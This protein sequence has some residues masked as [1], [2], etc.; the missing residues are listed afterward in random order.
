[1]ATTVLIVDDD[2]AIR[3]LLATFLQQEGYEPVLA[4]GGSDAL[5]LLEQLRPPPAIMLLDLVMPDLDG[6][7]VLDHLRRTG[8]DALPI[9][10]FSGHRPDPALLA[11]LDVAHRDFIAKPF[12]FD[13]LHLRLRRLLRQAAQESAAVDAGIRVYTL[14]ALRVYRG[15]TLLLDEG[16]PNTPAKSLLKVLLTASG[17]SVSTDTLMAHLWPEA[18]PAVAINRLRVAV[19]ELR[20]RLGDTGPSAAA[21]VIVQQA[22]AYA[23][24]PAGRCWT[25]VAAFEAALAQARTFVAQQSLEEALAAYQRAAA[26]YGGDFL[27]D[28]AGAEWSV[29][30]RE[31]LYEAYLTLLGELA[32]L[33]ARRGAV[34]AVVQQYRRILSLEPWR[35]E[36]YRRLMRY[37]ARAGRRSEALRVFAECR[38]ALAAEELEP[39]PTTW[40]LRNRIAAGGEERGQ[41]PASG[42]SEGAP[43]GPRLMAG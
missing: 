31:R 21:S 22:R 32:H 4:A 29:P 37:L 34:D 7:A 33:Q 42:P 14:G 1:M 25:D 36:V 13:E 43:S 27:R 9:L 12:D 39:S 18:D 19:H 2:A 16:W 24:D 20:R 41:P 40:Q 3:D 28:D 6:Y 38:R 35:E 8:Q 17:Q 11:A 15:E 26:L 10:L 5:A 30:T 23:F